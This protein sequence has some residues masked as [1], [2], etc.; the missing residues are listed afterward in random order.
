[1]TPKLRSESEIPIVAQIWLQSASSCSPRKRTAR[2]AAVVPEVS[3]RRDGM[4]SRRTLSGRSEPDWRCLQR[5]NH[6]PHCRRGRRPLQPATLQ[7]FKALSRSCSPIDCSRGST[8]SSR[9]RHAIKTSGQAGWLPIWTRN[10]ASAL[11]RLPVPAQNREPALRSRQTSGKP[12]PWCR[13]WLRRRLC[14]RAYLSQAPVKRSS[15][16]SLAQNAR[17]AARFYALSRE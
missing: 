7:S 4:D 5:Q 15:I 12:S 13:K 14:A 9:R 3:L 17:I 10:H 6:R 2:G 16:S 11:E 8:T 1:M